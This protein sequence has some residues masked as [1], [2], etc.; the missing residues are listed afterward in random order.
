[1]SL[2]RNKSRIVAMSVLYQHFL[3][4]KNKI[5]FNLESAIND[6]EATS[7]DFAKELIDGVIEKDDYLTEIANKYLKNWDVSRLGL[8][9][10][11]ILKMGIYEL[12]FTS[13]PNKVCIDEAITLAND[14]SDLAVSKMIN[15]VLD[16]VYHDEC[17]ESEDA[18]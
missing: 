14:Y 9:D 13:V 16:K 6:M 8:T 2:S 5:E 3:Y 15:G 11:A 7:D 17:G 1:M 12:I 10:Q 4:K 18:K